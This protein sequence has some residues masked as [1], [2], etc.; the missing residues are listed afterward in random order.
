MYTGMLPKTGLGLTLGGV[1]MSV[2]NLV[3]LGIA[4]AVIGGALLTL[5]RFGPRIAVEPVPVGCAAAASG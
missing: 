3:W 5:T 4:L 2:L 1:T